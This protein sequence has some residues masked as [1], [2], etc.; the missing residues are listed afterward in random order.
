MHL[1]EAFGQRSIGDITADDIEHYLRRR[2][3]ARVQIRTTA[4]V[5]QRDRL[6]PTTVHQELRVLRRMM[7]VAVRKVFKKYSQMKLQLKREALQKL[8]RKANEDR[9]GFVTEKVN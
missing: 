7:N 3:Q 2:L 6:K 8:N 1:K 4:G 9:P 5:I